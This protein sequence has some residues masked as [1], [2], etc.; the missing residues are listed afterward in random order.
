[1]WQRPQ[2]LAL[3]GI[4][5]LMLITLF[6]PIW[7]GGKAGE[8]VYSFNA[9][10]IFLTANT[11]LNSGAIIEPIK[12]DGTPGYVIYP[13]C[14]LAAAFSALSILQFKNRMNQMKLGMANSLIM[15]GLA[16]YMVITAT[17]LSKQAGLS[18]EVSQ[19]QIGFW[20]P[21]MAMLLNTF[22]N[23]FIR[24]DEKLVRSMD[25]IR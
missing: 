22:S 18:P 13:L 1:M 5:T 7:K 3:A 12:Q 6:T 15:S 8:S 24:R 4:I 17:N 16:V 25:R 20:L 14:A 23:R 21:F 2:T 19:F 11:G 9:N 10:G